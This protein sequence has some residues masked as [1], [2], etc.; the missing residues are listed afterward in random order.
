MV[1][2]SIINSWTIRHSALMHCT[3]NVLLHISTMPGIEMEEISLEKCWFIEKEFLKILWIE[4]KWD[5]YFQLLK[6]CLEWQ[7]G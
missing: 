7:N 5:L 3:Y 4:G 6:M 2:F 1:P